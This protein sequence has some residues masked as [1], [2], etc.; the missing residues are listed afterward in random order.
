MNGKKKMESKYQLGDIVLSP[1]NIEL[2]VVGIQFSKEHLSS[3]N[4]KGYRVDYEL[5]GS[6]E[7]YRIPEGAMKGY[8]LVSTTTIVEEK[9]ED[10]RISRYSK[11]VG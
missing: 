10:T 3:D 4:R 2:E 1:G 8:K 11:P 5:R 9:N 6:L 7:G